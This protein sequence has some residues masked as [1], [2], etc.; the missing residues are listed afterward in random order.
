MAQKLKYITVAEGVEK[1]E[2]VQFLKSIGCDI[3]QGF[4]YSKPMPEEAYIKILKEKDKEK[5]IEIKTE[6]PEGQF[7]IARFI[8]PTTQESYVFDHFVGAAIIIEYNVPKAH[9]T[10][11]RTNNQAKELFGVADRPFDVIN[12]LFSRFTRSKNGK[13]F[14]AALEKAT[15]TFDEVKCEVRIHNL[16]KHDVKH[17]RSHIWQITTNKQNYVFY[18]LFEDISEYRLLE[19]SI[20]KE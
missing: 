4:L 15:Q 8:N 3:I 5:Q 19:E 10:I 12:N 7:Q 17:I 11:M 18:I 9:T 1:E 2:Q 16:S 20:N 13:E 14:K 6:R